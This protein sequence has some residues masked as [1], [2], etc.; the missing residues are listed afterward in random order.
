MELNTIIFINFLILSDEDRQSN[1]I[2]FVLI[3][4]NNLLLSIIK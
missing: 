1:L 2:G 4:F 3:Q